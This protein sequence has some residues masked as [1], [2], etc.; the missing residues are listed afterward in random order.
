MLAGNTSAGATKMDKGGVGER[1]REL[2]QWQTEDRSCRR[3]SNTWRRN[4]HLLLS[5]QSVH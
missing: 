4:L 2:L 3:R 5:T 1:T